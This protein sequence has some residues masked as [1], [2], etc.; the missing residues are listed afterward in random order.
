M[1]RDQIACGFTA[2]DSQED[3][4]S[5]IRCLD[6]LRQEPFYVSYKRRVV[7]LLGPRPGGVYL[8]VGAGTGDDARA[9]A[10]R[11]GGTVIAIDSSATMM[12]E[13]VR[14]G[15]GTSV[16]GDAAHLPFAD[17]T[18]DGC[19]SDRTFQHLPDPAQALGE[20]LRVTKS[21]GRLVVVDPDYGTQV[22]EFPDQELARRVLRYRAE[23]GL[24]NGT[25]AHRM[26]AMFADL[27][28]A[29]VRAEEMTLVVRDH[30]AVDNVMGLR[31]WAGAAR[32][33]GYLS[34][35]EVARWERLFD[36][37]VATGHFMWAVAFFL[38]AGT[39]AIGL[40]DE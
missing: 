36:E 11:I 25:L 7:E 2:V 31:T 15:L 35:K 14:R 30:T 4:Q 13:A 23:R 28:L 21:G 17:N 26:P 22:M 40:E 1:S 5:C 10:K 16:V 34:E 32:S 6:T 39:S 12:S 9:V 29:Q 24:R 37:T 19:W 33:A 18:F 27:G 8:D 38:T 3:P 20:M